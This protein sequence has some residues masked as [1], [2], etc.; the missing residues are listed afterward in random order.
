MPARSRPHREVFRV[1]R[2]GYTLIELLIAMGILV[3]MTGLSLPALRGS[4]DKGRLRSAARDVQ[5]AL[6]KTRSLAI[7]TGERHDF[8]Y[9]IGGRAFRIQTESL[10]S[11]WSG[12]VVDDRFET[13]G[14][15]VAVDGLMENAVEHTPSR[16]VRTG[17]L[18]T[19][20]VFA[21]KGLPVG[22]RDGTAWE[23]ESTEVPDLA[24]TRWSRRHSFRPDGR[25]GS[26]T[27]RIRGSR[28]FDIEVTLRGLTG[29]AGY[30]APQRR[31]VAAA[32]MS[33][34]ESTGLQAQ[35]LRSEDP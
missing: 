5:A 15:P 27:I 28:D 1:E 2:P 24:D 7:R 10:N 17:Q 21:G 31:T 8:R 6:A 34:Q 23:S 30:A 13:A 14:V 25:S 29:I 19:G 16:I 18:P 26:A 4:L 3:A 33:V 12:D 32:E 11:F 9:E 35:K 22:S 20:V